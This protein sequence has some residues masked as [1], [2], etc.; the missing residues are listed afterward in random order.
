MPRQASKLQKSDAACWLKQLV[1]ERGSTW[2]GALSR[3]L[4]QNIVTLYTGNSGIWQQ[5]ASVNRL[6]LPAGAAIWNRGVS[7]DNGPG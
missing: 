3:N 6:L 2:R 5:P 4:Q 7:G 1:S